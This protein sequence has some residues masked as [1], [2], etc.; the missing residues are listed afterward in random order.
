[1][2]L[3]QLWAGWRS[4]YVSSVTTAL[5]EHSEDEAPGTDGAQPCV[6]CSIIASSQP[7]MERGVVKEGKHVLALLNAYPYTSGH[8]LV[9]PRRHV[10][11]LDELDDTERAELWSMTEAAVHA[12]ERAYSPDGINFGANLGRAA[13]AGIPGHLHNHVLARWTGDT[14]FMTTVAG[15]RVMPEPLAQSWT[16]LVAGWPGTS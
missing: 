2:S 9:L 7:D 3:E 10:S 8:L 16:K 13:G 1:M 11:S 6:F 12:L 4:S 14:N 5:R 15:V